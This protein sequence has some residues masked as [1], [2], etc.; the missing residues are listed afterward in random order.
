MSEN[1]KVECRVCK[2]KKDISCFSRIK[3]TD[4]V[5]RICHQCRREVEYPK[6]RDAAIKNAKEYYVKN[7]D[8]TLTK[9]KLWRKEH[10]NREMVKTA[11]E[12]AEKLGLPFNITEEDVIIP[13]R[14]PVLG[15]PLE[16]GNGRPMPNSPSLDRIVPEL[17]YVKG[18]VI[19]VSHKANTIKNNATPEE[20][21]KVADFYMSLSKN[22]DRGAK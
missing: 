18:N 5:K 2:E 1:Q 9:R 6:Y 10:R 4:R 12:R 21:R 3:G 7:R 16:I 13:E 11:K 14:C 15:I 8:E 17:G 22:W 20:I 19:V